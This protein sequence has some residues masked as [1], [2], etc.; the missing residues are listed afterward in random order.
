MK[1]RPWLRVKEMTEVEGRKARAV[2]STWGTLLHSHSALT[3]LLCRAKEAVTPKALVVTCRGC[4]GGR[5][6]GGEG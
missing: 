3:G 6:L 5:V 2:T 1:L 4:G